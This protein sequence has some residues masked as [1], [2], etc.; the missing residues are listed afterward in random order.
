MFPHNGYGKHE[1][2]TLRS[3]PVF[4]LR[5][6]AWRKITLS[7]DSRTRPLFVAGL[8]RI[9]AECLPSTVVVR[10]EQPLTAGLLSSIE[11]SRLFLC[12][13]GPQIPRATLRVPLNRAYR[14]HKI[15]LGLS[16]IRRSS[17]YTFV[18]DG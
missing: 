17:K 3:Y 13:D 1:S 7:Y 4:I 9:S 10:W 14:L 5:L 11:L 16:A 15:T 18:R 8:S 2:R 12:S 6:R